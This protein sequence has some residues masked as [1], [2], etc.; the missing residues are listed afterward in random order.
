MTFNGIAAP[1]QFVSENMIAAQVPWD[2]LPDPTVSG[3][4]GVV[5]THPGTQSQAVTIPIIPV[6]P[7]IYRIHPWTTQAMAL[8]ADGT[9]AA[10]SGTIEGFQSHPANVGD[11]RDREVGL[12]FAPKCPTSRTTWEAGLQS[13]TCPVY[14]TFRLFFL[15]ISIT[16]RSESRNSA[17]P[18]AN[19]ESE[20]C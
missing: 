1:L 12:E 20:R 17:R 6:A 2:V 15:F 18:D 3:T 14:I 13:G 16:C 4:A 10:A 11:D 19:L 9:L 8:N 7:G 5:V